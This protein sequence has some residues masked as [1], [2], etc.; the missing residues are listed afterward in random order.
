M[1]SYRL[2]QVGVTRLSDNL[3]I[4]RDMPEW[5]EYRA[6]I[7]AGNSPLPM[8]VPPVPLAA[9]KEAKIAE[10]EEA[11]QQAIQQPL[12]YMGHVFQADSGSQ[13]TL[14]KTLTSLN[15]VG[16]VP[17]GFAW[18]DISNAPVSMTLTQLNGLAFAMLARGWG[19]FQ[20]KQ[21]L[22]EAVRSAQ[23]VDDVE[24]ITW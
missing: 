7:T 11:Y 1:I 13:D 14:T 5:D 21:A 2:E 12:S 4:T 15:A 18:W 16:S 24:I 10:I 9:V 6:W 23:T 20:H 3:H 22:K 8:E 17:D 19:A